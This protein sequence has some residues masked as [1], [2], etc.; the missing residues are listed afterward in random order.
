MK[1]TKLSNLVAMATLCLSSLAMAQT[2]TTNLNGEWEFRQAGTTLWQAATVPGTVHTD[3]LRNNRIDEPYYRVN[4]RYAQWV[5]KCDWEY[6]HTFTVSEEDASAPSLTMRFNGL[7]TYAEVTLNGQKILTADNMFRTWDVDVT[8]KIVAG[9]NT[10]SI[11]FESA[12]NRGLELFNAYGYAMPANNDQ[13][14]NGGL[15]PEETVSVFVRKA[16]YHFGW[17]WGPRFVTSGVY[18]PIEIIAQ[19]S[20]R[21]DNVYYRQDKVSASKAEITAIVTIDAIQNQELTLNIKEEGAAKSFASKK[22]ALTIGENV[23]E[24]PVSIS[25]P[26]LWW[27]NGLGEAELYNMVASLSDAGT[28]VDTIEDTIGVRSLELV[29][30]PDEAGVSCYFKLNGVPVFMKGANH[31][32]NDLFV[33][34]MTDEVYDKEIAD[35]KDANMNMLRVWGGG[36]YESDYFY[37]RCNEEGILVWQD[38]MFACSMYPNDDHFY[39]NVEAE[40]IDNVKRLRNNPCIALWCGNNEMDGGWSEYD[41]NGGWGWKQRYNEAQRKEQWYAYNHIFNEILPSVVAEYDNRAYR[42]SSP[43]TSKPEVHATT[44]TVNDGDI[45]Y[46][47]VWHARE[48][49]EN[50]HQV[51]GRFMSEYG[52]QSFPEMRTIAQYALPEDY[53]IDSEVLLSHQR[54]GIGNATIA[55]YLDLYQRTPDNFE[56]FIYIQ[57]VLQADAIGM[58]IEA[59][60]HN[61][62]HTM[63]TLYWQINDCWPVASWSSVDYYRR[64][65]A[66]HYAARRTFEPLLLTAKIID[67]NLQVSFVNDALTPIKDVEVTAVVMNPAGEIS[68]QKSW[69]QSINANTATLAMREK[70]SSL[71]TTKDEFIVLQATK[72]G[73]QIAQ[74]IFYPTKMKDMPLP[75]VEP[76]INVTPL[77]SGAVEIEVSSD[78]LVKNI[79]LD[80]KNQEGFFSDN[81]FDVLPSQSV[82]VTFTPKEG[83]T[84]DPSEK[85]QFKSINTLSYK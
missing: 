45:H 68:S 23:I 36:I 71:F 66:L 10:I 65:K 70:A 16:P 33:D 32:P 30:E 11:L 3:L 64:W 77:E 59:H 69:K 58:A 28:T 12:V 83:T 85:I 18:R 27:T 41:P 31:I 38:F 19:H 6:R 73:E 37:K 57:Q 46:W 50:F 44:K 35:A 20:A 2:T 48:P 55:W 53:D 75:I 17:D 79:W 9:E 78:K 4:E 51:L 47:G 80:F 21:I 14:A 39:K 74:C 60:R 72:G 76:T 34:R 43:M 82:K 29:T 8:H 24:V 5:D 67:E 84:F 13:A 42:Q 25:K 56:D 61:M 40:A 81:Y 49:F 52:F 1:L 63:G 54:S 15:N 22:V 62:P 7:D 26:R